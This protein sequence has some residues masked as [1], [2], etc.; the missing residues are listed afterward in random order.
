MTRRSI[1]V[2]AIAGAV[3][4][5][6]VG[7]IFGLNGDQWDWWQGASIAAILPLVLAASWLAYRAPRG[8]RR[9]DSRHLFGAASGCLVIAGSAVAM[10]RLYS[11][12]YAGSLTWPHALA[13]LAFA[14]FVIALGGITFAIGGAP[15]R[16]PGA[17]LGR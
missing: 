6:V 15:R 1:A 10:A 4:L 5:W 14:G 11:D 17:S 12:P 8:L 3:L 16:R 9:P 13:C 7:A 2:A